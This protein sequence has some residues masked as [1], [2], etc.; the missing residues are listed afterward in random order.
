MPGVVLLMAPTFGRIWESGRRVRCCSL[1]SI[2]RPVFTLMVGAL[3]NAFDEV[4]DL[5]T[6]DRAPERTWDLSDPAFIYDFR[7][8][9]PMLGPVPQDS[10]FV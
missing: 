6:A 5:V 4:R 8:V 9:G 1:P 10:R 3:G 2:T 7:Q